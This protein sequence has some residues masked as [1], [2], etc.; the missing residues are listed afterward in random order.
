[1]PSSQVELCCSSSRAALCCCFNNIRACADAQAEQACS[2]RQQSCFVLISQQQQSMC[3]SS[4]RAGTYKASCA[5]QPS[6]VVLQ[7]KQSRQGTLHAEFSNRAEMCCS[8][9]R[10]GMLGSAAAMAALCCCLN[11]G[12]AC[13][14][15]HAEQACTRQ[16]VPSSRAELCCSS[17][18]ASMHMASWAQQHGR[19][20]LQLMQSRQAQGKLCPAAEQSCVAAQAELLCVAA[21]TTSGHVLLLRQSMQGHVELGSALGPSC[22]APQAV[23]PHKQASKQCD[24]RTAPLTP[25][26][27]IPNKFTFSNDQIHR[28]TWQIL[29]Y[30]QVDIFHPPVG[31]FP[32]ICSI[33]SRQ[34]A[35]GQTI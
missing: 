34:L 8:S 16:A 19:A 13:A 12:R 24:S 10:A 35:E 29:S 15:A 20:A 31:S 30:L 9:Y 2:A 27:P 4:C 28:S 17:G 5:Q 1:M 3:C 33:F 21:S 25:Q 14:A 6:R 32:S 23:S 18:R 7:L 26:L 22:A 11:N